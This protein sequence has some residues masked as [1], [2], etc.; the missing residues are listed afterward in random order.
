M[1]DKSDDGSA[2]LH[3]QGEEPVELLIERAGRMPLPPYIASRGRSMRPTARTIRRCSRGEE[4]A[5]A[6]P[7]AALHFTPRLL[8][9]WTSAES[10]ARR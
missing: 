3:F 8:E 2:L 1:T 4:G 5:V 9:P 10:A 6:A 7:T